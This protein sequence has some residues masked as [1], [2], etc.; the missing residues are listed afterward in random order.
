MTEPFKLKNGSLM[1][2]TEAPGG[3]YN[4]SQLSKVADLCESGAAIAKITED[5]RIAL[6]VKEDQL[7]N[8]QIELEGVGLGARPYQ[9]GTH[10][11]VA[12]IGEMC[13]EHEQD[14]LG[15]SVAL[16]GVL[17]SMEVDEKPVK[18]GINGCATCC[19]PCHTL[20]IS[21][22]G[23]DS[24]Y[25]MSIGGK[26]RQLPEL[27]NYVAEGIPQQEL[28]GL[29]EKVLEVY[30]GL[31]ET[32]EETMQEVVE[33]SG[34]SNFIEALSPYSQDAGDVGDPFGMT[35][36][37]PVAL[38]YE[39]STTESPE[40]EGIE[41][42]NEEMESE[43]ES[44]ASF[45]LGD[46]A[47]LSLGGD[48]MDS[49]EPDM[50]LD[51]PSDLVDEE[52]GDVDEISPAGEMDSEGEIS[53]LSPSEEVGADLG[54]ENDIAIE[55]DDELELADDLDIEP[56]M[57]EDI[58]D[59]LEAVSQE[60]DALEDDLSDDESELSEDLEL[61][62]EL[63]D[64]TD[65]SLSFVES[66]KQ[67][68][69]EGNELSEEIENEATKNGNHGQEEDLVG[70]GS[71]DESKIDQAAL[72]ADMENEELAELG[73]GLEEIETEDS[74]LDNVA[75][76]L[77]ESSD[78]DLDEDLESELEETSAIESLET[79][80]VE[81]DAF[82]GSEIEDLEID[83]LEEAELDSLD[84]LDDEV[85][86][87]GG[88]EDLDLGED[89]EESFSPEQSLEQQEHSASEDDIDL[90]AK[91]L[92]GEEMGSSEESHEDD[93]ELALDRD[94]EESA[95][96]GEKEDPNQS[97]R[98]LALSLVEGGESESLYDKENE[99][100]EVQSSSA[101]SLCGI[102][103]NAA[104]EVELAFENGAL[105]A[106]DFSTLADG[107][108]RTLNLLGQPV[109]LKNQDGKITIKIASFSLRLPNKV[110]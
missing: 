78:L 94:I 88:D 83:S 33:R 29:I 106:V 58:G 70:L 103:T 85:H 66:E 77:E 55:A 22:V 52:L 62:G 91:S 81:Q 38:P 20:D 5:Q 110:A 109:E 41:E 8:I 64:S 34:L 74:L 98:D 31:R 102:E 54:L 48:A 93:L 45:D 75:D 71:F 67:L 23:E 63:E 49:G 56:Q 6:F 21:V 11:P 99:L 24:G 82:E 68:N 37:E 97:D 65:D 44:D 19:V 10:H 51:V 79:Q 80:K 60:E 7:A 100:S 57:T 12:C 25:K 30:R 27:A 92:S 72:S 47:D 18:I 1:V 86:S 2:I 84:D 35:D 42:T 32:P 87:V 17:S 13:P 101:G 9:S 14:A 69:A 96:I 26:N 15:A 61:G 105:L 107:E 95:S 90:S 53:D 104:G 36:Q 76:D 39:D 50:D 89:L 108:T 3:L 40:P 73:D 4:A 59:E 46:D 28:P 16:S 43:L